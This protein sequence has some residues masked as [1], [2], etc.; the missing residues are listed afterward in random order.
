MEFGVMFFGCDSGDSSDRYRTLIEAAKLAEARDFVCIWTP[1]RHFDQFGGS[2][3]NPVVTSAALAMI[4]SRIQLRA[5]SLVSPLH[6]VLRITEEWSMVDNLSNGRVAVSFGSGWNAND[7]VFYPDRYEGRRTLM[8]E[9]IGEVR[10]LWDGESITRRNGSGR[11]VALKVFPRPVQRTLPIWITSS[12]SLATC[13]LAGELGANLLTH[14]VGQGVD[15]L[16]KKIACYRRARAAAGHEGRGIVS[17]MLHTFMGAD[18]E[19]ARRRAA[20]PLREYLRAAANLEVHAAHAG[21]TL[22]AGRVGFAGQV[23]GDLM[24][25]LVQVSVQRYF[26]EASL[27]G[28]P[29]SCRPLVERLAAAGVDEVASLLDFGFSTSEVLDSMGHLAAFTET[30]RAQARRRLDPLPSSPCV[31]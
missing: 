2:F 12:A 17:V 1:E 7:F 14:L 25:E 24:D 22:S 3:S 29:E 10:R 5:G 4:T 26:T 18:A 13:V 16:A 19:A 31:D 11:M 21:G 6:D 15:E 20:P 28:T 23:E 8:L 30:W 27:I 9:Q